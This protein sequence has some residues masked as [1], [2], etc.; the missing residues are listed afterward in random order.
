MNS[1]PP[2]AAERDHPSRVGAS[3]AKAGRVV[4][5]PRALPW[6]MLVGAAWLGIVAPS[7]TAAAAP[8][9]FVAALL[10]FGMPHGAAD[11]AVAARLAPRGGVV[12][13]LGG[14]A[15]YLALMAASLAAIALQPS[16]SALLFL[17]LTVFHFGMA[18]ATA[19][20]ADD[21]GPVAR[22]GLVLGRGLLLLSTAFAVQP[23]E[24]WAPFAR[25][26]AALSPWD[27]GWQPD[28]ATLQRLAVLGAV[29]GG[30]LALLSAAARVRAGHARQAVLDLVEH[31]LVATVAAFADPLFAVGSF[32]LCVHAFRHSRRLACTHVI[33]DP[34]A[35]S[36]GITSLGARLLRVHVLSLPLMWPTAACL[37]VLCWR[38]GGSDARTIADASIAFYMVTTLPHHLLGLRLP[39]PD[40]P[41][42]AA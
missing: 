34:A 25:I 27:A 40:M 26:G 13:R 12:G 30:L 4:S 21:D 33:I 6:A 11:W 20:R 42:A 28:L 22:W 15:W 10:A 7:V 32:F 14:F 24:A 41:P 2:I 31:A 3:A 8:W 39:R 18:D 38:L 17:A 35:G 9:P 1:A 37:A 23:A 5:G 36:A 29:T 16:L 19:V